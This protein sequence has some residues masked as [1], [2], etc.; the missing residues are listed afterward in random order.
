[1]HCAA[2][3]RR[4]AALG[5]F[6]LLLPLG[7]QEAPPAKPPPPVVTTEVAI[8]DGR[9]GEAFSCALVAKGEQDGCLAYDFRFPSSVVTE[10]A[11]N[12][13]VTGELFRPLGVPAT[14]EYPGVV[15]FH[16]IGPGSFQFERMVCKLLAQNGITALF[17]HL[18]YYAGRNGGQGRSAMMASPE[19]FFKALAQ[20][21]ADALRAV[22]LLQSFPEV[23]PQKIG[24]AGVSLGA[25]MTA[26]AC[27]HDPRI[28]RAMLILGGGNLPAIIDTN[29]RETR[30]LYRFLEQSTP[31]N[32]EQLL[33]ELRRYDPLTHAPAMAKLAAAGKFAMINAAE[34]NVIPPACSRELAAAVGCDI[35]WFPG[36][37]HYTVVS[38]LPEMLLALQ[39]FFVQDRPA[40]WVQPA[41]AKGV[42][43]LSMRLLGRVFGGMSSFLGVPPAAGRAHVLKGTL[44]MA[45]PGQ[46]TKQQFRF[47]YALGSNGR[48]RLEGEFPKIG[49]LAIGV[50]S[51]PWLTGAKDT[52]FVGSLNADPQRRLSAFIEPQLLLQYEMIRG[53]LAGVGMAPD[54]ARQYCTVTAMPAL[55]DKYVLSVK[56]KQRNVP[57]E[58]LISYKR[59]ETPFNIAADI[60]GF[61]GTLDI[62]E[63]KINHEVAD[64]FFEP[65]AGR[66]AQA[67]EQRDALMMLASMGNRLLE[68]IAPQ[69]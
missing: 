63:W 19:R 8:R 6:V 3:F 9:S 10:V 30:D 41:A 66:A 28:Q 52:L 11:A 64:D 7:A 36:V 46:S 49:P 68:E 56:S 45:T 14:R 32:R 37:D 54:L 47:S 24:A 60:M 13:T 33:V 26:N 39:Q 20:C 62:N 59:D 18:P 48:F 17:F 4:F 44:T 50:G 1:M 31:E 61:A 22:D 43:N 35:S 40:S 2:L 12:N 57:G 15:I 58:M 23:D 21:P 27:G 34:D 65:P 5:L 25:I 38:Q 53:S 29:V 67:V 69:K 42:E 16:I 51:Y 55:G